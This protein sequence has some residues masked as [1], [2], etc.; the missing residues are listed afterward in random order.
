MS[1]YVDELVRRKIVKDKNTEEDFTKRRRYGIAEFILDKRDG[2]AL[3]A[4]MKWDCG[5]SIGVPKYNEFSIVVMSSRRNKFFVRGKPSSKRW[6]RAFMYNIQLV[7][8]YGQ[9][10]LL[11]DS[12]D[13]LQHQ[14]RLRSKGFVG[15]LSEP[16]I[17]LA[18]R[19]VNLDEFKHVTQ[20]FQLLEKRLPFHIPI[21]VRKEVWRLY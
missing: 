9:L 15:L 17:V 2:F 12:N 20:K 8:R 21:R 14:L 1:G 6:I 7:E 4:W 18:D 16:Y 19:G 5:I 13:L 3:G 10:I 11:V